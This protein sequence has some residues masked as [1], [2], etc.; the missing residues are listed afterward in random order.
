[1][2][3]QRRLARR[4]AVPD[5]ERGGK[6]RSAAPTTARVGKQLAVG[7]K[8][9]R[10]V[11]RPRVEPAEVRVGA[12]ALKW[13]SGL[14]KRSTR[15]SKASGVVNDRNVCSQERD[16]DRVDATRQRQQALFE[17]RAHTAT[18]NRSLVA[19]RT[20][21]TARR[22]SHRSACVTRP[23]G[24]G[25]APCRNCVTC[26][27]PWLPSALSSS[28]VSNRCNTNRIVPEV[29]GE[30]RDKRKRVTL[31]TVA[32]HANPVAAGCR[33]AWSRGPAQRTRRT[34][35]RSFAP[36]RNA[37]AS[38]A[39]TAQSNRCHRSAIRN[40]TDTPRQQWPPSTRLSTHRLPNCFTVSCR[41]SV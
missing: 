17:E 39:S 34:A 25:T 22:S 37:S 36:R 41:G 13:R 32:A 33:P 27:E 1:V 16:K 2:K 40:G 20:L 5:R 3:R 10:V 31:P 29:G 12:S 11:P 26:C 38:T 19:S 15:Q 23:A 4:H 7:E 30:A 35:S 28:R 9:A 6:R 14:P 18:L 24:H 8:V 21:E